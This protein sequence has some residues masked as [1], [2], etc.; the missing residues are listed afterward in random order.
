MD[1]GHADQAFHAAQIV[2]RARGDCTPEVGGAVHEDASAF[3]PHVRV[4]PRKLQDHPREFAVR[5]ENVAASAEEAVRNACLFQ[6][7]NQLR[8]GFVL[9]NQ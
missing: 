5:Q 6:Q 3:K 7:M 8:Q 2:L 4:L 1:P 9:A